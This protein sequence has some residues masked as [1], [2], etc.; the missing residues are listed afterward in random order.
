MLKKKIVGEKND[1]AYMG[2][3][4]EI[5]VHI[6]WSFTDM[7]HL[8]LK[9]KKRYRFGR[10]LFCSLLCQLIKNIN[11]YK[12][13]TC[14]IDQSISIKVILVRVLLPM[15]YRWGFFYLKWS[16]ASPSFYRLPIIVF[17]EGDWFK[18]FNHTFW[19]I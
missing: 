14:N 17:N 11:W 6:S 16:R 15:Q 18:H 8:V 1:F 5:E 3:T 13:D 9:R 4:T 2:I 12:S 10:W 19:L 7:I